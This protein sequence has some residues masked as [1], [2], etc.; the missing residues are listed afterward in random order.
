MCWRTYPQAPKSP[1]YSVLGTLDDTYRTGKGKKF[2]FKLV[3]PRHRGTHNH[4]IWR[5]SSNPLTAAKVRGH[6]LGPSP[7]G[8]RAGGGS[9]A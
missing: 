8:G 3:W 7:F 1:N 9:R 2:T 5:Q 4:N 6:E